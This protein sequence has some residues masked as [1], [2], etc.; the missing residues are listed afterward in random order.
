MKIDGLEERSIITTP[1]G[2]NGIVIGVD[3]N[4]IKVIE[5]D[6]D[7]MP[8]IQVYSLDMISPAENIDSTDLERFYEFYSIAQTNAQKF[9]EPNDIQKA[10]RQGLIAKKV[11]VYKK[12]GGS[13]QTTVWVKPKGAKLPKPKRKRTPEE[14]AAQAK[15]RLEIRNGVR[16]EAGDWKA[17]MTPTP[18][19]F[20]AIQDGDREALAEYVM[21][22]FWKTDADTGLALKD[23][24][25]PF[26]S[27]K[28]DGF[29]MED[30]ANE[31][32]IRLMELQER[33]KIQE[34]TLDQFPSF[35]A[36]TFV[37][38][39]KE[40]ARKMKFG[41]HDT[42]VQAV[43]NFEEIE[44][45]IKSEPARVMAPG[46]F[47]AKVLD[48]VNV[49][50]AQ[51]T[52]R[53]R[54]LIDRSIEG[55]HVT[56][57]SQEL[58]M[59]PSAVKTAISRQYD[60]FAGIL[61]EAGIP[62][63]K[64]KTGVTKVLRDILHKHIIPKPK[65]IVIKKP[66]KKKP[67]VVKITKRPGV[68]S[69]ATVPS[70][71]IA[72]AYPV[73][74]KLKNGSLHMYRKDNMEK[75]FGKKDKGKLVKKKVVDKTGKTRTVWVDPN[76]GEV[77]GKERQKQERA[78]DVLAKRKEK[79]AGLEKE[80]KGMTKERRE[81]V[82]MAIKNAV[83]GIANVFADVL[84]GGGGASVAVQETEQRGAEAKQVGEAHKRVGEK[85]GEIKKKKEQI[86]KE[87]SKIKKQKGKAKKYKKKYEEKVKKESEK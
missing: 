12:K 46:D 15:E 21:Q 67:K 56:D 28:Q 58:N 19:Q 54:A 86:K 32:T 6:R 66:G 62:V 63:P 9:K 4:R 87:E 5:K 83:K 59:S 70:R 64:D 85:K 55:K 48:L 76:K 78:E 82:K 8:T 84:S 47:E 57:I 18:E 29:D 35:V 79:K 74:I 52:A 72:M 24:A 27:A 40:F 36:S 11:T 73:T 61:R 1:D 50:E 33:G 53:D 7:N 77:G 13:Y 34:R 75:A 22:T 20:K 39:T 25:K 37:R 81:A 43:N 16:V 44:N 23:I 42:I 71:K 49:F 31:A 41:E 3:S 10:S 69:I 51:M 60:K 2:G 80:K 30:L 38:S 26:L 65:K 45:K 14:V 68:A 17:Q